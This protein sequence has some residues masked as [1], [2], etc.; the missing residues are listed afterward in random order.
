ME[1]KKRGKMGRER[2]NKKR[3]AAGQ[4]IFRR[5]AE[6]EEL[7]LLYGADI[8][9][10]P[11]MQSE[12]LFIQ[13]G[14]VSIFEHSLNVACACLW[15]AMLFKL[16]VDY[17]AL[18]RGALL[19]DYFLYDWHIPDRSHRWHGI[20]HPGCALKNAEKDFCL[21][22]VERDMIRKHM[23]PLTLCPPRYTE[24]RILCIADKI[25]ACQE[26]AAG[27]WPKLLPQA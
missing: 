9:S 5:N 27:I 8:L 13:H 14:S 11:G 17:A 4:R 2:L 20:T 3:E 15:I 25:C 12:K 16:S 23:F 24:S 7:V 18:V 10:S 6:I 21:T 1:E 26:T 19:H 22:D